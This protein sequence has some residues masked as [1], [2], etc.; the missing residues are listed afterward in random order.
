MQAQTGRTNAASFTAMWDT[1]MR[2]R[3]YVVVVAAVL[4]VAYAASS[5]YGKLLLA[6]TMIY[7]LAVAGW[8]VVS[9]YAGQ[10]SLGHAAFFGLGAYGAAVWAIQLDS[11][12]WIGIAVA[13]VAAGILA[14]IVGWV[15]WRLKVRGI[16]FALILFAVS[17]LLLVVMSNIDFVGG[18]T[19]LFGFVRE[20]SLYLLSF[21]DPLWFAAFAGIALA[22]TLYGTV[23]LSRSRLGR[24]LAVVRHD[25]VAAEASGIDA[26]TAKVVALGISAVITAV[27]GGLYA[28]LQMFIQP[29]TVFGMG[30]NLRF[31][32]IGFL[33][34]VGTL[35]GPL[36]GSVLV[37]SIE[38]LAVEVFRGQPGV[39]GIAFGLL[40]V[41]AVTFLPRGLA[42]RRSSTFTPEDPGQPST[43]TPED[44]RR[45]STSSTPSDGPASAPTAAPEPEPDQQPVLRAVG[46]TKR[47]GG[48]TVVED[49]ELNLYAG[50]IHGLI[51]PNGAG[52][53]TLI[54]ILTGT[55][56]ADGGE[57]T[58]EGRKLAGMPP[59]R[60]ARAGIARTFQIP[61]PLGDLTLRE[62]VFVAAMASGRS[63]D[64]ADAVARALDATGLAG[65]G[66]RR[67]ETLNGSEKRRGEVARALSQEPRVLLLDE[68]MSGLGAEEIE[69]LTDTIRSFSRTHPE[70]T[71]LFVEHLMRV[72]MTLADHITVLDRGRVISRGAPRDVAA[73]PA[74][75]KAYLGSSV[76]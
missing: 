33:G 41:A 52:K 50:K 42:W 67:W 28:Q 70:M 47:F 60:F 5:E 1:W 3:R 49:V 43:S 66:D 16:Y 9:G 8:N 30:M 15:S 56:Q 14:M 13:A 12:P 2:Y 61:R 17:E 19:G 53:T 71:V 10:P 69:H 40:L 39:D 21:R 62:S 54:N 29:D 38:M 68:P 57:V 25:E 18:T 63:N 45:P 36:V 24:M 44:Q 23:L 51:G 35:W 34:G 72:M 65:H 20:D 73:D 37:T 6:L 64:P 74:V 7:A 58:L 27:A 59:Y 32:L 26:M 31:I 11:T 75:K 4:A 46:L 55:I 76:I 48:L 22:I